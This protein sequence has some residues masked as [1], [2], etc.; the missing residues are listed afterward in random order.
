MCEISDKTVSVVY[1][2]FSKIQRKHFYFGN[3][4]F[5]SKT[6]KGPMLEIFGFRVFSQFR[7]VW[8]GDLGTRQKNSKF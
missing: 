6:L 8:V 1:F 4:Y 3:K 7:P 5:L 2:S